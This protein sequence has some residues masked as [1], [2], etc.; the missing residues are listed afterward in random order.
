MVIILA[1]ASTA[2]AEYNQVYVDGTGEPPPHYATIS[3]A[4]VGV[5][6]NTIQSRLNRG[7][8]IEEAITKGRLKGKK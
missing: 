2:Q 4:I 7:H 6:P 3:E 8:T 1:V 5:N